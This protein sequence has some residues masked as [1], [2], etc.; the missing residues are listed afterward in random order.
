MK[1]KSGQ[2]V[3]FKGR[4]SNGQ[5]PLVIRVIDKK[6]FI[7]LV[8][9]EIG[10][11]ASSFVRFRPSFRPI[12]PVLSCRVSQETYDRLRAAPN[13]GKQIDALVKGMPS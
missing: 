5:K 9:D 6:E 11:P 12:R 2:R 7:F 10:Y 1:F 13:I 3:R 4:F 8:G